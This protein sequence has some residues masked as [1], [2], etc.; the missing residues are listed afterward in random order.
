MDSSVSWGAIDPHHRHPPLLDLR[1]LHDGEAEKLASLIVAILPHH[2]S[3]IH[4]R[5]I[6]IDCVLGTSRALVPFGYLRRIIPSGE[7]PTKTL[8]ASLVT[9]G[10]AAQPLSDA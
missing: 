3:L 10:H 2:N 6:Q 9:F 4:G 1:L 8:F 7:E 5:E